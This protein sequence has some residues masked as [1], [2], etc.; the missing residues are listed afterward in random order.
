MTRKLLDFSR[1]VRFGVTPFYIRRPDLWHGMM[2]SMDRRIAIA[3]DWRF[4]YIRIPKAANSTVIS[5]LTQRF[6]AAA[7]SADHVD[8]SQARRSAPKRTYHRPHQLSRQQVRSL[9][10]DFFIF[11]VVRNPFHRTLSAFL[12]KLQPGN[13]YG[14]PYRATVARYDGGKITFPGFCRYLKAGG[15]DR[16][17]HWMPQ[18]QL[19]EMIG[20]DRLDVVGKVENLEEDLQTI[21]QRI[22]KDDASLVTLHRAGPKSTG[23]GDKLHAHY[24]EECRQIILD[25]FEQD[26]QNFD[27]DR[28]LPGASDT[29]PT[30]DPQA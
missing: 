4:V 24:D 1:A 26:F 30:Q 16:N 3:T 7:S 17:C 2:P 8:G 5:T 13:E 14:D 15:Q 18:T 6:P 28:E 12:D 29:Q 27:Y 20:V 10:N 22:N 9:F 23:A 25:V 11:T 21:V 19:V